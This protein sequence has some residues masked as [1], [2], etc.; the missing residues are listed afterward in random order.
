[1]AEERFSGR[2]RHIGT[3]L[4]TLG[5]PCVQS[6]AERGRCSSAVSREIDADQLEA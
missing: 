4:L 2:I 1:M 3:T 5:F 6:R